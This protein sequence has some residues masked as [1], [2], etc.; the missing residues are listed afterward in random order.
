MTPTGDDLSRAFQ[1][2]LLRTGTDCFSWALLTNHAHLLLRPCTT[3]LAPFMRR[4]LT[5]YANYYT[6]RHKRS[7][8]LFQ[9]R[10]KSFVCKVDAYQLELVRY[11]HLNPL[12]A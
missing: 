12:R 3:R 8:H 7:G 4:L 10:Y 9:N 5:G 2:F 11:I 6:L 1:S